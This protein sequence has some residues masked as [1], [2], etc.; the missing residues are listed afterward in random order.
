MHGCNMTTLSHVV[1]CPKVHKNMENNISDYHVKQKQTNKIFLIY[2]FCVSMITIQLS[3]E[4][5]VI[6]C[7]VLEVSERQN[8]TARNI[9]RRKQT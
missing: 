6:K 8:I 2:I 7:S 5:P 1:T 4:H 3:H 9:F